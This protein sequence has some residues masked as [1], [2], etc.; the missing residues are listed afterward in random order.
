MHRHA[1]RD[2]CSCRKVG[3]TLQRNQPLE[4]ASAV[5]QKLARRFSC[6]Q[7]GSGGCWEERWVERSPHPCTA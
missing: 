7:H 1:R 4:D 5:I 3:V 2:R 6:S